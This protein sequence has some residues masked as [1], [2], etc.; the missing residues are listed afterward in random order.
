MTFLARSRLTES[1][2]WALGGR[3]P[4]RKVVKNTVR[5]SVEQ[6]VGLLSGECNSCRSVFEKNQGRT[7]A[8]RWGRGM[9][10][11]DPGFGRAMPPKNP[12][13]SDSSLRG[14]FPPMPPGIL[15]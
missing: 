6:A 13:R 8:G 15:G 14:S 4:A 12:L 2:I 1:G 5:G 9:G 7:A 3:Q 11:N 10:G